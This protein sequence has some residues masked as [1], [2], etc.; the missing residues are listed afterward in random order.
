[1][2]TF[3]NLPTQAIEHAVDNWGVDLINMSF[4]LNGDPGIV[5]NAIDYAASKKVLMFAAASNDKFNRRGGS[6]GFPACLG[7]RVI[8]VN[9]HNGSHLPSSFSPEGKPGRVNFALPGQGIKTTGLNGDTVIKNGTSCA[10]PIAV[11]IVALILDY[12]T[13]LREA[14]KPG[15]SLQYEQDGEAIARLVTKTWDGQRNRLR[16]IKIIKSIMLQLMTDNKVITGGYNCVKPWNLFY[17][18]KEHL[19][20]ITALQ[21]RVAERNRDTIF[22]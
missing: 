2:L 19:G 1:M 4:S 16:D 9:S 12:N 15:Q 8:C 17:R 10:T 22:H 7:D 3:L 14:A 5:E 18:E 21:T 20:V 11:G 13:R 6:I